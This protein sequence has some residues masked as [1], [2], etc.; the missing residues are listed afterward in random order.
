MSSK[1]KRGP[2]AVMA[3]VIAIVIASA[4][5]ALAADNAENITRGRA[6][7]EA[8][9]ARCHNIGKEGESTHKLAP[10]F[11]KVMERYPAESLAESL[12]EG[13]VSGHPDMP[14]F[15]FEPDEIGAIVAYLNSLGPKRP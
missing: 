3:C 7:L 14:V 15:I 13:I 12:A 11:R 5:G 2:G 8:N 6:L 4:G 1:V 10:P 9:C